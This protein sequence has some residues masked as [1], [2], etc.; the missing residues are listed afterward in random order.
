MAEAKE[1]DLSYEIELTTGEIVT[2]DD[3]WADTIERYNWFLTKNGYAACTLM[4]IREIPNKPH[5]LLHQL[6]M[7]LEFGHEPSMTMH[8][9]HID[10][11]KLNDR[12][13]NL[14]IITRGNNA[15]KMIRA[16][17]KSSKYT[18]ISW[19][20]DCKKWKGTVKWKGKVWQTG[21]HEDEEECY[22]QHLSTLEHI[23][24][25][26]EEWCDQ[27]RNSPKPFLRCYV[28]CRYREPCRKVLPCPDHLEAE[29]TESSE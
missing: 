24:L 29:D 12:I 14:R 18:G 26:K 7:Y 2:I 8:I 25:P 3:R 1:E 20:K 16:K 21:R 15:R 17:P 9:D 27:W 10:H 4:S 5:I 19:G 22:A 23:G 28:P 6:I 11:N 13:S